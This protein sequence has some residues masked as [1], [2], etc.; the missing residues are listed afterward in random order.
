MTY[1]KITKHA[2][3]SYSLVEFQL[4]SAPAS[5][6]KFHVLAV[7]LHSLFLAPFQSELHIEASQTS[8]ID[9]LWK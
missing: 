4:L 8:A 3:F 2:R 1:L 6:Y 9:L 7:Y 5:G